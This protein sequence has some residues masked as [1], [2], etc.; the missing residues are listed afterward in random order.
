MGAG[1][2]VP[3]HDIAQHISLSVSLF[4]Q[5]HPIYISS[6]HTPSTQQIYN[7]ILVFIKPF[8]AGLHSQRN[9]PSAQLDAYAFAFICGPSNGVWLWTAG[10]PAGCFLAA[11]TFFPPS[12][13]QTIRFLATDRE[14]RTAGARRPKKR[15]SSFSSAVRWCYFFSSTRSIVSPHRRWSSIC[16]ILCAPHLPAIWYTYP[17]QWPR[18]WQNDSIPAANNFTVP[19]AS[20]RSS[21]AISEILSYQ[22]SHSFNVKNT[23]NRDNLD[24]VFSMASERQSDTRT[25][26]HKGG[27]TRGIATKNAAPA[28]PKTH[29]YRSG[30]LVGIRLN[31]DKTRQQDELGATNS[32]I[33]YYSIALILIF[34]YFDIIILCCWAF[35]R[36]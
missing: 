17:R 24:S 29:F 28:D 2:P 32:P 4:L 23:P 15:T 21:C 27:N 13:P 22:A 8:L 6:I 11:R 16:A 30:V 12:A 31:W 19:S 14:I 1:P 20:G 18:T 35:L 36:T 3:E 7:N 10:P 34:R 26:V 25:R 9:V 5:T 33:F